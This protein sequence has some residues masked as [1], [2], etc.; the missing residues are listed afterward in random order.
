[1]ADFSDGI[2]ILRYGVL[3]STNEQ[4]KSLIEAGISEKF[5]VISDRQ[6][7]A[8]GRNGRQWQSLPGNLACS[9][10]VCPR[11]PPG[12]LSELS[13][14]ASVAVQRC[15]KKLIPTHSV[16]IKWPNDI[17]VSSAKMSGIL[18]EGARAVGSQHPSVVVGIGVN[19]ALA[20]DKLK[21]PATCLRDLGCE[22]SVEELF[23]DLIERFLELENKWAVSGLDIILA[24]WLDH[25][26]G[27]G[28]KILVRTSDR[29]LEG[30]FVKLDEKGALLLRGADGRV[31]KI[32]A[33][34]V[35]L[36]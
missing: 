35:F 29:Q 34:D 3:A 14:V 30:V 32:S 13:F 24:E 15:I 18:L 6:T 8:R 16:K 26:A 4:A 31:D 10:V 12:R 11:V 23:F 1:M 27:L 22:V 28:E 25:A 2:R 20:P 5:V 9:I 33:G 21:Y 19:V 36:K 7:D 17:L